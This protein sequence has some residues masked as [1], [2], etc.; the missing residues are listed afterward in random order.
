VPRSKVS[1]S[2]FDAQGTEV[3]R[4]MS[5]LLIDIERK[6]GLVRNGTGG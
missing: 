4:H 6:F 5:A 3:L 1:R 2:V